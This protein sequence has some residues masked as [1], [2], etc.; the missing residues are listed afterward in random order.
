M[1][2]VIGLIRKLVLVAIILIGGLFSIL[3]LIGGEVAGA[4]V[5][6]ILA[7]FIYLGIGILLKLAE[8]VIK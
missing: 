7:F 1:H 2:D 3:A 5:I 4:I 6:A 8:W